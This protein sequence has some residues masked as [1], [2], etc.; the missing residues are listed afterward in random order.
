MKFGLEIRILHGDKDVNTDELAKSAELAQAV[1][2]SPDGIEGAIVPTTNGK[3]A[4][5]HFFDPLLPLLEQWMLKMPW[6]LAGDTET[7]FLKNSEHAFGFEPMSEALQ[8]SFYVGQGNEVEQY[9]LEP[10]ALSLEN[11]CDES[12]K[13][14]KQLVNLINK[15]RPGADQN[16]DVKTLKDAM[17]EAD[18]ALREYRNQR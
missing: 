4:M 2:A 1:L 16:G 8:L 17:Q 10:L 6:C 14:V 9:V 5:D 15:V 18:K 13:A 11:F 12:I 7:V 3:A